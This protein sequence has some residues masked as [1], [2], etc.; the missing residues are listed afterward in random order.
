MTRGSRRSS[1][2]CCP[3]G[4]APSSASGKQRASSRRTR[5]R[6]CCDAR[7]TVTS[8]R[9]PVSRP[10]VLCILDGLGI[11]PDSPSN[12]ATRADTPRL[13][14]ILR[15]QPHAKLEASGVAVGLPAGVMGNSEVGHLTMG[16]GYAEPQA[17]EVIDRAIADGTFFANPELRAACAAAQRGGTLPLM[18]LLSTGGVHAD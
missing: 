3:L 14:A 15:D 1:P 6:P 11:A 7:S 5:P 13:D 2:G 9:F 16:A 10:V 4:C 8:W 12:A 18:G 17:L